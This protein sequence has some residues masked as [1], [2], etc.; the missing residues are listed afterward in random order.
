MEPGA[1]PVTV[2]VATPADAVADP[3]P[4][5][6]P[7]PAVFANVTLKELSEP[8][9]TVLPLTSRI[10]AVSV[11]V[12]PAVNSAVEPLKAS[13]FAA[14]ATTVNVIGFPAPAANPLADALIVTVPS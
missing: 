9:V 8:V 3:R 10:V 12:V 1:F 4:V 5:T 11:R 2:R 14:P 7:L 6:V 13:L